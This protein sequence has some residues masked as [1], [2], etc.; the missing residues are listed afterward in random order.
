MIHLSSHEISDYE[1]C[2]NWKHFDYEDKN[3]DENLIIDE[4]W[5]I[6]P[7]LFEQTE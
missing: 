3:I 7:E 5:E 2:P 1:E 6:N 4:H